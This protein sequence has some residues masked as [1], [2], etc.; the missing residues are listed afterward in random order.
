[1]DR[2]GFRR[3]PA[4]RMRGPEEARSKKK[5]S[6]ELSRIS[7]PFFCEED[8]SDILERMDSDISKRDLRMAIRLQADVPRIGIGLGREPALG[9]G[10]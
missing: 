2:E 5:A 10:V 9:V 4:L 8:K 3:E 6:R 1:M 7:T